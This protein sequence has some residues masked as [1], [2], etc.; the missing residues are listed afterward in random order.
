MVFLFREQQQ[1]C[2][3]RG[4]IT[5]LTVAYLGSDQQKQ[6]Q[7]LVSDNLQQQQLWQ[8]WK[9]K[10]QVLNECGTKSQK[11]IFLIGV[12][13]QID[14]QEIHISVDEAIPLT[15]TLEVRLICRSTCLMGWC[16]SWNLNSFHP[17]SSMEPLPDW[18]SRAD[19]MGP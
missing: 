12:T 18:T 15:E 16:S 8:R 9:I 2:N 1:F 7:K 19:T 3:Y 13:I 10:T 14:K 17:T 4:L 11:D 5:F 6:E